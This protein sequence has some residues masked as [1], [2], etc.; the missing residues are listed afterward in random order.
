LVAIRSLA[1]AAS[2]RVSKSSRISS[3]CAFFSAAAAASA[4]VGM[5]PGPDPPD[6]AADTC[7]AIE[8]SRPGTAMARADVG[9]GVREF[10]PL[11]K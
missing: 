6:I 1:S 3:C 8:A 7:A 2:S 9:C 4:W 11:K 5:F 10:A